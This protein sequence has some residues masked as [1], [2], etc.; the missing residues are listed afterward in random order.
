MPCHPII[1][2]RRAGGSKTYW[3]HMGKIHTDIALSLV[4]DNPIGKSC[5]WA[6][7][8]PTKIP[9]LPD[10]CFSLLQTWASQVWAKDYV[11]NFCSAFYSLIHSQW[12]P[13]ALQGIWVVWWEAWPRVSLPR[14]VEHGDD[15][16][17]ASLRFYRGRGWF[18]SYEQTDQEDQGISE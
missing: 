15:N 7:S 17:E 1:L 5:W 12:A 16:Q 11:A 9:L 3:S 10:L 6:P 14:C 18:S 8:E 2:E 13:D 4:R